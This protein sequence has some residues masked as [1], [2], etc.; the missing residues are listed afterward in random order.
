MSDLSNIFARIQK[1]MR[2]AGSDNPHEAEAAERQARKLMDKYSLTEGDLAAHG[3]TNQTVH[4]PIATRNKLPVTLATLINLIVKAFGVKAVTEAEMRE[5]QPSY[6]VR[7]FGPADRVELAAYTHVVIYR[8]MEAAWKVYLKENAD[9]KGE[10]GARA[11]FQL[12][13]LES[14]RSQIDELAMTDTERTGIELVKDAHYGVALCK[15]KANNMQVSASACNS[16][17][18][19]GAGFNLRRPVGADRV[20]LN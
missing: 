6:V 3:I 17:K 5:T 14:I 9:R 4:C 10:R 16:G 2:L 7:Y 19:A 11:G 20:R 15:G 13:F 12:G 8:A 18:N 1:C